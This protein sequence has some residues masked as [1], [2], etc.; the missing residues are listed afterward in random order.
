MGISSRELQSNK[1]KCTNLTIT[2]KVNPDRKF[3]RN[4]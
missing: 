4:N 1:W 3:V 2:H